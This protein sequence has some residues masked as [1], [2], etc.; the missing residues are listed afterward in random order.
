LG[1]QI[2]LWKP[3]PGECGGNWNFP[4]LKSIEKGFKKEKG[5]E[6]N[7]FEKTHSSVIHASISESEVLSPL[8]NLDP[9]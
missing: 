3:W 4:F 8:S 5:R 2:I 7:P 1:P 9:I 6:V